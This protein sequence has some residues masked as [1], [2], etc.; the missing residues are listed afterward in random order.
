MN[1]NS[2]RNESSISKMLD[3]AVDLFNRTGLNEL[4]EK[5]DII[6]HNY[7]RAKSIRS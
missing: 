1:Q 5:W 4:A 2:F 6:L 7:L 3:N